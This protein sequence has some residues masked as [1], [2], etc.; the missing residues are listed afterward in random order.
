MRARPARVGGA[1][2]IFGC[3]AG[4]GHTLDA[5]VRPDQ[6]GSKYARIT[7][8]MQTGALAAGGTSTE[9]T[10][11]AIRH[12]VLLDEATL[13]KVAGETCA[14]VVVR[15]ASGRDEPLAQLDPTF[16]LDGEEA[17][18][19]VESEVVSVYDYDFTGSR[20]VVGVEGMAADKLVSL[21]VRQPE[22]K[23][24]R[25]IERR[26]RLCAGR[27]SRSEVRLG[28]EH[29]SWIVGAE[30]GGDAYELDFRWRV[31]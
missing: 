28:L 3:I 29:P 7:G 12:D 9:E 15:T 6:L 16:T 24:F 17:R 30:V 27:G 22:E 19:V 18:G 31:Q 23:V 8:Y 10:P 26:G 14:D 1:M 5:S 11:G 13:V 2:V 21:S 4:C 25:V 20:E